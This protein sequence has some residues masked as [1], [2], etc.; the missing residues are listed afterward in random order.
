M[1]KNDVLFGDEG[2]WLLNAVPNA[3]VK[4]RYGVSLPNDFGQRVMSAAVRVNSGGS[5]SFVS[6]DGLIM[7]NHHVAHGLIASV[8]TADNDMVKNGFYAKT[9]DEE[10]KIPQLEVN[11]LASIEDVTQRVRGK[12]ASAR[13][14]EIGKIELESKQKTGLRSDVV[15][16]YQGGAYHLYRYERYTDVRLVFAPEMAIASF[17]GDF[18]NYEFPRYCLDVTFLRVYD[19]AGAPVVPKQHL[20]LTTDELSEGNLL[21]VAGHPGRTD[22]LTSYDTLVDVRDRG[23]PY[24]LASLR[25]LEISYDQ[26]AGRGPEFARRAEREIATVKNL[27]KRYVGQLAALQDP[28]FMARAYVRES[29]LKKAVA[30]VPGLKK[31]IGDPWADIRKALVAMN[32]VNMEYEVFESHIGFGG[33]YDAPRPMRSNWT[34]YLAIA[35]TIVRMVHEDTRPSAK[36]L[37]E[38]ADAKRESLLAE[39]YS[40]SPI[41]NDLE[42]WKLTDAFRLLLETFGPNDKLVQKILNGKD[43]HTRA[44][45]LVHG[46]GLEDIENRKRLVAGGVKAVKASKDPLIMLALLIDKRARAARTIMATKVKGVFE[47]AYARIADAQFAVYGTDLYPDATFTLRLAMGTPQGLVLGDD[48]FPHYTTIAGVLEHQAAHSGVKPWVLPPSWEKAKE[49]VKG[50]H[51]PF[52][53]ITTHDSHGGNSGSPVLTKDFQCVGILFDGVQSGQGST[54]M[55]GDYERAVCVSAHGI[56]AILEHVYKATSLVKELVR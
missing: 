39:L 36:R 52:N 37:S 34:T 11:V 47:D 9:R 51:I 6:N 44:A 29:A 4:D 41:Y 31:R 23:L 25:R 40:P 2:M 18:D 50:A 56:L 35:R 32:K 8:S 19:N 22:R 13:K 7:T 46:T 48:T 53:F 12:V 21:F 49:W 38:F 5:A 17:G 14:A 28:T 15:E 43:P 42:V 1:K 20:K 54:F 45:E 10:I 3:R 16:L 30:K 24:R 33:H 55:Y 26:Y 27:R